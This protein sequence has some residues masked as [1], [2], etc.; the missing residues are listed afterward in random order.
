VVAS[1]TATAR[2]PD[3]VRE[4]DEI[5]PATALE[6]ITRGEI[7]IQIRTAKAYPRSI[8][9][10]KQTALEMATVDEETAASCCYK[11][12]PRK[13]GD[14]K[15]IEGPSVRLAEICSSAWG[16]MRVQGRIV[17]E[18][19]R[20]VVLAGMAWDLQTNTA[21][22]VEVRRRIT[23]R[24]GGRYSDDMINTTTNAGTSI[25]T[26]N[27]VLHVVPRSYVNEIYAKCK[28][29]ARGTQATLATRRQKLLE[30]FASQGVQAP[31]VFALLG[32][33]GIEDITLD[34]LET[35]TG[36]RTAVREGQTTMEELLADAAPATGKP[37]P[38][39]QCMTEVGCSEAEARSILAAFDSLK[40]NEATRLVQMR[41]LKGKP[42][43]LLAMLVGMGAT[44]PTGPEPSAQ[45]AAPAASET[46][47]PAGDT[48]TAAADTKTNAVETKTVP[49]ET[50]EAKPTQNGKRPSRWSL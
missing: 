46:N 50:A 8:Q 6:A 32:V 18:E 11:L 12:P 21:W 2:R 1:Q 14:G 39:S 9:R 25:A 26:R 35:A 36:Y 24:D 13:G 49:T 47:Q 27:A 28:E 40:S 31:R 29:V 3:V 43:E 22:S 37:D 19:D 38:V 23:T 45:T 48:Q 7:D 34:H 20:H 33:R 41:T 16:H 17:A 42:A 30:W 44:R 5:I 15:A 4:P 10:F